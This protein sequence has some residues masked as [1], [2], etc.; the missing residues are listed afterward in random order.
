MSGLCLYVILRPLCH[1][2]GLYLATCV[3]PVND[4]RA[5]TRFSRHRENWLS[6]LFYEKKKKKK[7]LRS[8]DFH[9][10]PS[11]MENGWQS[12]LA[13]G[14]TRNIEPQ[15]KGEGKKKTISLTS[16]SALR[17]CDARICVVVSVLHGGSCVLRAPNLMS[18]KAFPSKGRS[19]EANWSRSLMSH[20]AFNTNRFPCLIWNAFSAFKGVAR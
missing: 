17:Q 19:I 20:T 2:R 14:E 12:I 11:R 13:Q 9:S 16:F 10:P 1:G 7:R 5:S 3:S 6:L 8:Q 4:C 15:V 18:Q